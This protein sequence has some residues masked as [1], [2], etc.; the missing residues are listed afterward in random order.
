VRA[1]R[2]TTLLHRDAP[3]GRGVLRGLGESH[4]SFEPL[5]VTSA[6]EA[7]SVSRKACPRSLRGTVVL[8]LALSGG[9][10]SQT[11]EI[12]VN[13][14]FEIR[15]KQPVVKGIIAFGPGPTQSYRVR[16]RWGGREVAHG[17][18]GCVMRLH[19]DTAVLFSPSQSDPLRILYEGEA[20]GRPVPELL[21]SDC[22]LSVPPDA[23]FIDCAPCLA[24]KTAVSCAE[25]GFKRYDVAARS[26]SAASL[27]Q[28]PPGTAY[29]PAGVFAYDAGDTPYFMSRPAV[30]ELG[31]SLCQ[32]LALTPS[33]LRSWSA[34]PVSKWGCP[35]AKAWSGTTGQALREPKPFVGFFGTPPQAIP[36]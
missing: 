5:V 10:C 9:A 19:R 20:E 25:V 22:R 14:W 6:E 16:S 12:R 17:S 1:S 8:A 11:T 3:S 23:A 4:K 26:V 36:Q 21:G 31:D 7:V 35:D 18:F 32:L 15:A 2:A 33:G 24:G 13:P 30:G 29:L 34:P 28:A 27:P